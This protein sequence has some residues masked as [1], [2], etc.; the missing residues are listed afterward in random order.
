[1]PLHK[2][3]LN[4]LLFFSL[5]LLPNL[6]VFSQL[7]EPADTSY[8]VP[9]DDNYNLLLAVNKGDMGSILLLL[10]RGA[11]VNAATVDGVTP[12][13]YAAENGNLEIVKVFTERGADINKKPFNGTTA[14]IVAAKQNHY[15]IAEYLVSRKVELNARDIE[16]VTAVNYAAAYNNF[17]VMDMLVFYG[18]DMELADYN[19]NTPLISAAYSNSLDAADLL[20]QNGAKIDTTDKDGNTALMTALQKNNS[21]M[22]LLLI[23]KGADINLVNNGGYSA[24]SYAVSSDN[25]E[26]TET[27]LNMGADVNLKTGSGYSILELARDKKDDEIIDLLQANDA[28][29]TLSPHFNL[30]SFGP[31]LDFNGT[32]YMNGIQF[33]L[34]DKKYRL[35]L[36]SGFGFRPAGN[37]ILVEKGPYLTYQYWERR[38]YFYAGLQKEFDILPNKIYR[39]TGPFLGYAE[40]LS[41]GGYAGSKLNPETRFV[42]CPYAGWYYAK[43]GF[44]TWLS[45][46]YA[47]Y[48][49]PKIAP[50][51]FNL[52]I[53]VNI[54]LIRKGYT[55][56]KIS[57]LE[58]H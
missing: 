7:T 13:M 26:I 17:D 31:Y 12:L 4:K 56:K 25:A 54:S 16:G 6:P 39:D 41:F 19:G 24:L 22:A 30:L 34:L 58:Q 48:H 27:L 51:R 42:S 28:K 32:D 36:N 10:D 20:L 5:L 37:R 43:R 50:G 57:W 1:M 21:E 40:Q 35:G 55:N 45:Y 14:L 52:G 23:D 3:L 46:Q 11:S 38:Y 53:S 44:R 18:A 33:S 2:S 47:D 15:D 9:W 49:T 29:I 8:F